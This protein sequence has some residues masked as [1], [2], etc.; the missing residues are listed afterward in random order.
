M[1]SDPET[2]NPPF[3]KI[4]AQL[5][6]QPRNKLLFEMLLQTTARVQDILTLTVS[7]LI[8]LQPG[9]ILPLNYDDGDKPHVFSVSMKKSFDEFLKKNKPNHQEL[10]FKSSKGGK[11]LSKTSV[12]RLIRKWI[13]DSGINCPGLRGLRSLGQS[14]MAGLPYGKSDSK[15]NHS[16]EYKFTK[17]NNMTLQEAV[18][19]ELEKA[20]ISGKMHPGQKISTEDI[21]QRMGVSR[22]PVREAMARL[23]ERGFITTVPKKGSVINELSRDNL[24]EIL[25]LRLMLECKAVAKAAVNIK[26]STIVELEKI[27]KVFSRARNQNKAD[28]LLTANRKFHMLAYRDSNYPMLLD[29]INQL[30]DRV[31]PYYNIMFRQS[32]T[33]HPRSGVNFHDQLIKALLYRDAEKAMHWLESDLIHSAEFVLELFD[34]HQKKMLVQK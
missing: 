15:K 32:I 17:I 20:I 28:Q 23:A 5:S 18:F 16:Y 21:A 4:R 27:N 12:S 3:M 8:G 25:D 33:T 19:Q 14:T 1:L 13:T 34:L 11:A 24:K 29:I 10:L 22:I 9:A 31:S 30:W 2:T 7:D 26:D 6:E